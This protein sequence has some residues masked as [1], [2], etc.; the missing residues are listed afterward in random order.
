MTLGYGAKVDHVDVASSWTAD[1]APR[2]TTSGGA[3]LDH[4]GVAIQ[5]IHCTVPVLEPVHQPEVL[6]RWYANHPLGRWCYWDC[7][8]P[9]N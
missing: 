9:V 3:K 2:W 6:G 4:W 1:V 7:S 8:G 5:P